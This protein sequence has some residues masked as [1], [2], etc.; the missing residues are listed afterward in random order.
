M[1]YPTKP[2]DVSRIG[3]GWVGLCTEKMQGSAPGKP[4]WMVLQGMGWASL[5]NDLFTLK[6]MPGQWPTYEESR[7]M[8]WDTVVRGARGIL[9]WGTHAEA[10][11]SECWK[12]ITRVVRE[13]ADCQTLLTAP[14]AP[15]TP[16]VE[17]AI[18]GLLPF[19]PGGGGLGVQVL[20]K[21]VG[22][23][24]VAGRERVLLSRHLHAAG[25]RGRGRHEIH[26]CDDTHRGGGA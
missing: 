22:E 26:G 9:Y 18:F 12:G 21:V 16:S 10:K 15:V 20:G 2:V 25:T 17:S 24:L 4:V 11:D 23:E 13:L 6:P 19:T 14:D 7:F 5:G 1:P 3:L 8:A